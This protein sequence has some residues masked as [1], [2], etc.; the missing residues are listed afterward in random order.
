MSSADFYGQRSMGKER[1]KE[2]AR[3]YEE[4]AA[5]ISQR[6]DIS[7]TAKSIQRWQKDSRYRTHWPRPRSGRHHVQS[8]V[9]F[10]LRFGLKRADETVV[11]DELPEQRRTIRDWK[12]DAAKVDYERTL[13]RFE[14][15]KRK[16]V[17]LD[18]ICVAVGKCWPDFGPRSTCYPGPLRV[19]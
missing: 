5:L 7:L 3:S 10:I 11:R 8:W 9:D 15:K 19:G 1:K 16:H 2:F 17:E 4:L 12:E 13:F 6:L 18:E 14:V